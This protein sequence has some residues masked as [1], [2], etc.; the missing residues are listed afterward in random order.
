MRLELLFQEACIAC[1]RARVRRGQ[2]GHYP[3]R[4]TQWRERMQVALMEAC[5]N[6]LGS[7]RPLWDG[8]VRLEVHCHG[9]RK[10]ADVDNLLKSVMDALQG[11]V[12]VDDKQVRQAEIARVDGMAKQTFVIVEPLAK[13][14]G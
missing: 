7:L 5:S 3:D 2:G 1:P 4:Y 14:D 12:I 13:G 6:Q 11:T 10:N 8:D 9:A